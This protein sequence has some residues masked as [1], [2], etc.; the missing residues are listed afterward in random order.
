MLALNRAAGPARWANPRASWHALLAA[1]TPPRA[2]RLPPLIARAAQRRLG[3]GRARG[4]A[5]RD[6]PGRGQPRAG[7][8][9]LC[10]PRRRPPPQGLPLAAPQKLLDMLLHQPGGPGGVARCQRVAP[11]GVYQLVGF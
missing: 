4:L 1:P 7:T 3:L 6:R 8:R 10:G 11:G 5:A 9:P 2:C